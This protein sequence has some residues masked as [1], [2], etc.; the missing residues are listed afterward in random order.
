V[1]EQAAIIVALGWDALD[2]GRTDLGRQR[3]DSGLSAGA[4]RSWPVTLLGELGS[5]DVEQ[6]HH[7]IVD[8]DRVAV[9]HARLAM[10]NNAILGM[11]IAGGA[12]AQHGGHDDEARQEEMSSH[13][14]GRPVLE[15]FR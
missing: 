1:G 4:D 3:V 11:G 14:G 6:A 2:R 5:V 15:R 7:L 13:G 12:R 8:R 9:D 10:E